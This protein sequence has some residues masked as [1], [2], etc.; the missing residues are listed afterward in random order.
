MKQFPV[1]TTSLL[2]VLA[3]CRHQQEPVA[4]VTDDAR[5]NMEAKAMLQGIWQEETTEEVVFRAEGDTIY[6]PN[7]DDQ[8]AHF[9]VVGDSLELGSHRY[10]IVKQTEHLLW[11]RNKSGETMKLVKSEEADDTLAFGRQQPEML[12]PTEVVKKDSVVNYGGQ[13]YHWYV[14]VNPTRYRVTKTNY[15]SEGVAVENIF[16]DNII[17]VSLYQN[18]TC[19]FSRD[20]KK[21][22]YEEQ[23][24]PSF[25]EQAILGNMQYVH[26]DS[27]GVHFNATLCIPDEA[28]CYLV[29]TI[30]G[31]DGRLSLK[32]L[33]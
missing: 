8:P 32:L 6:Y 3:A 14:A 7:P 28:S 11:F 23:V 26:T 13:R 2:L 19:L 30:I 10:P 33:E 4:T 18:S 15:N 25:L 31:F 24:P 21:G 27:R 5:E 20:F 1:W 16:Y 17:H 9:R 12:A 22:M 29:E